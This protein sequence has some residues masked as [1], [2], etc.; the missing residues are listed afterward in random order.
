MPA[1]RI[2]E[3]DLVGGEV[4]AL[5]RFHLDEAHRWSPPGC[6]HALPI[7][8]LRQ[9]DVTFF[10]AWH[11][12]RLAAIGAIRMLDPVRG[13]LKSMRAH[14]DFRGQG[15]GKAILEHL[16]EVARARGC[17]WLGLETG[18]PEAYAPARGLYET[19]GFKT[20]QPFGGYSDDGFSICMELWLQAATSS[21]ERQ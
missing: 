7:E 1:C 21:P 9:P 13:E 5:L 18:L 15:V 20:C 8:Q 6:V 11:N 12:D 14:P 2:V 4:A 10:S 16:I 3:D 17:M 19:Y